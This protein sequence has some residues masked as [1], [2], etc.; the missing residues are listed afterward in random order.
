MPRHSATVKEW[1]DN[2][3]TL[4]DKEQH[5]IIDALTV[6]MDWPMF[7]ELYSGYGLGQLAV[8]FYR[9]ANGDYPSVKLIDRLLG[10]VKL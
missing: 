7:K 9:V 4:S 8:G 1:E 6:L 5:Q 2:F 3:A 10:P